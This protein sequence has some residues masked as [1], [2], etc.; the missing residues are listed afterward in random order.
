MAPPL[1]LTGHKFGGTI[2][3]E[4]QGVSL[5]GYTTDGS[6][7]GA[8]VAGTGAGISFRIP[9]LESVYYVD[10]RVLALA[11]EVAQL[12]RLVLRGLMR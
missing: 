5:V 9:L 6:T 10:R 12:P 11:R 8:A 1:L 4:D 7:P 3:T 2:W